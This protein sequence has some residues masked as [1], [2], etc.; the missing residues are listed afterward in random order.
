MI[1]AMVMAVS[2]T[3]P[4]NSGNGGKGGSKT[5]SVEATQPAVD[6]VQ[7]AWAA[8]AEI[9]AFANN[10][11]YAIKGAGEGSSVKFEGDAEKA[12]AVY[13]LTPYDANATAEGNVITTSFPEIQEAVAG[14]VSADALVAVAEAIDGK[15]DFKAAS[16]LLKFEINTSYNIKSVA[17]TSKGG[18]KV[19]GSAKIT[20][21]STPK[22]S[23]VDGV[24]TITV[25]PAV[26]MI[27][28]GT[29]YAAVIPQT[30]VDGFEVA[31][32]DEFGRVAK[33]TT[34]DFLKV[35]A[36]K[37]ID[38]GNITEGLEFKVP[39]LTQS[40]WDLYA[41]GNGETVST[42][43]SANVKSV[44]KVDAPSYITVKIEGTTLSATF[45][46]TDL[47]DDIRFGKIYAEVVTDEGPA[48]ITI[49]TAQA[50]KG[51]ICFFDSLTSP[52]LDAN[53]KGNGAVGRGD[54][55]YGD[56]Y[57][58]ITGTGEVYDNYAALYQG[59]KFDWGRYNSAGD[60]IK[61]FIMVTDV[62]MDG[63]CG[64]P[65]LFNKHGYDG[66]YDFTSEQNYLVFVAGTVG[67]D[68]IGYYVANCGSFNAMDS[69]AAPANWDEV[70]SWAR[71]EIGNFSR[72]EG[73]DVKTDWVNKGLFSLKE[74]ADGVLQKYEYLHG[75]AMWW[76]NDSPNM[77]N[78]PGYCGVFAKDTTPTKFKNFCIAVGEKSI[79]EE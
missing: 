52:E 29:Y 9:A 22:V 77:D 51:G 66:T 23:V 35:S 48:T 40:P 11:L 5:V 6:G 24:A 62:C 45:A 42:T 10:N 17:I 43:L 59:Q 79:A 37:S 56:G 78:T 46:A 33:I 15:A 71:V 69:A 55:K 47:A 25:V 57:L 7:A 50:F 73:D 32:T 20:V 8:G 60:G 30:Y 70:S 65:I 63:G 38:L 36:G 14:G 18:E 67:A 34:T 61:H 39:Q 49:L 74:D 44:T 72:K 16:G 64:G 21:A 26:D 28:N 19:A 27:A 31:M 2:C 1:A 75:G 41:K 58:E 76:W 12:T 3:D 4:E 68:G 53:W 13:L 54:W